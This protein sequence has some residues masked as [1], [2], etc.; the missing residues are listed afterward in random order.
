[1]LFFSGNFQT[2]KYLPFRLRLE[3]ER[4]KLKKKLYKAKK[5]EKPKKTLLGKKPKKNSTRG[6]LKKKHQYFANP[7]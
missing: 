7:G 3:S 6:V 2:K 4:K 1:M 5:S